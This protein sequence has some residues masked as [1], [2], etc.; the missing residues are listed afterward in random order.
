MKFSALLLFFAFSAQAFLCGCFGGKSSA[1]N[2]PPAEDSDNKPFDLRVGAGFENPLGYS[3]EDSSLSWKMPVRRGAAQ[4]AYRVQVFKDSKIVADTRKVVSDNSV[5]V[6]NPLGKIGSRERF[7]WRVKI[8]DERGDESPWSD[9]A[10]FEA[11]LLD[12]SDWLGKWITTPRN[13]RI[14]YEYKRIRPNYDGKR[15]GVPPVYLRKNFDARK[16][17]SARLYVASKGIFQIYINGEKV[18]RDFWSTGWTEYRKRIQTNTYDVSELVK[19][20]KNALS[21]IAADGWYSGRIQ[22][23]DK[24]SFYGFKPELLVQ[25]EIE[26][27]DGS[28]QR[29]VS[30]GSWRAAF[31]GFVYSDIYDGE[32]FDASKEPAGWKR[33]GFDDSAWE[34]AVAADVE[35]QP[36]LQ[37]R[38]NQPV[39]V[40]DTLNPVSVRKIGAG[41]F[42]F[43]FGQNMVGVPEIQ[44]RGQK[45][46]TAKIRFAEMLNPDGTL[47]TENYRSAASTD[48]YKFASSDAE[49]YTP[50]FTYH[51]YRYLEIS[52]LPASAT[53]ADVSARALVMY[54]DMP[55]IGGFS[56]SDALVNRL[57]SNIV[58]GQRSNYFSVPTDC[59]Q[60]D[61]RMGWLGDAQVFMPTAAFNMD[62]DAFFLKWMFDVVDWQSPDGCFPHVAPCGW[63]GSSPAWSDAGVICP[64][65]AYLAYGDTAILRQNYSAMAK[66]LDYV[67]R[68]TNGTFVRKDT[69]F[70]DWLQPSTTRGKDSALWRGGTPRRL[71]GT[72]Y[73]YKCAKIMQRVAS[74]LGDNA[75]S[76]RY[77]KLSQN[78]S[79]AFAKHFLKDGGVIATNTQTGYLLAL[80]FDILPENERAAVF[81]KFLEKFAADGYR[82]DTGFVGTPLLTRVLSRFGRH[83]LAVNLLLSSQ[84]PSWGYSIEQGATTMWERWNSYSHKDGFGESA[85][86]S[87]NHYAYGAIGNWLYNEVGG[88]ALDSEKAGY[89]NIVFAPKM[90]ER[91]SSASVFHDTPYGRA[92]SKWKVENGVMEWFITIP[93]NASGRVVIPAEK[94]EFATFDGAKAKSLTLEN[95]P[96]GTYKI[97]VSKIKY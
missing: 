19:S 60:R 83:D 84:Y 41:T 13:T 26:Y 18:G 17:K 10:T 90:S 42:V 91:L 78:I 32:S 39:V 1:G 80:D 40:K 56:C 43:D 21:A 89:K 55:E 69:G 79:A 8:W 82:L 57:Q 7:A 53:A 76:V 28:K 33:T 74:V 44:F 88:L 92:Q 4:S 72:A 52:G 2:S 85:M 3:L 51:G 65:E 62:V 67:L 25:L 20:G 86:N 96:C 81:A 46:A 73:F 14:L 35:K 71:I 23:R 16:P 59:P 5:R 9:F 15:R 95:V 93:P 30:D 38:R 97:V 61:E 68:E 94:P 77:E 50:Q 34:K 31:G 22:Y 27:A 45:G 12:N 49:K 54:N 64:F 6:E 11:G 66:W 48:Y 75:D 29:I 36:L 47:Y 63:G 37:P 70:G 58:W 87:F 24:K